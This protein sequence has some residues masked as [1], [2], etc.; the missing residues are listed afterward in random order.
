MKSNFIIKSTCTIA[1]L[2]LISC[3][4]ETNEM[5]LS[6]SASNSLSLEQ[7]EKIAYGCDSYVYDIDSDEK[8]ETSASDEYMALIEERMDS[9]IS[10]AV[11]PS[12]LKGTVSNR[13]VGVIKDGTCGNYEEVLIKYDCEDGRKNE[14]KAYDYAKQLG[15]V[16]SDGNLEMR[17]CKVPA[18]LFKHIGQH[19]AVVNFTNEIKTDE[20]VNGNRIAM[21]A[22]MLHMDA[23]DDDSKYTSIY[24]NGVKKYGLGLTSLTGNTHVNLDLNLL[25]Y[26][27]EH[28]G[29]VLP[30]LG[31]DYGVFGQLNNCEIG[32]IFSDDEDRNNANVARLYNV[33]PYESYK[34]DN[35]QKLTKNRI[36]NGIFKM[37]ENT[38]LYISHITT[39][40][41][42]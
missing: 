20:I 29:N 8:V 38:T 9:L 14:T 35:Y 16:K 17:F 12:H 21:K 40:K 19:Y 33:S 25:Y 39:N 13:Y 42:Q 34:A 37:T 30:D 5:Y 23:E 2:A 41:K 32:T 6:E 28:K 15:W 18:E 27:D 1:V 26:S 22:I 7:L 3:Q 11:K 4:N 31:F 10:N 24:D 36:Y